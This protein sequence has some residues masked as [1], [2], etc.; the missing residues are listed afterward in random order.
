MMIAALFFYMVMKGDVWTMEATM[1][2]ASSDEIAVRTKVSFFCVDSCSQN[3]NV[4]AK[5]VNRI[6]EQWRA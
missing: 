2:D 3:A 6:E 4:E 5:C 1:P